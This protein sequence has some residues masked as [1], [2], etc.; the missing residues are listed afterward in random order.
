MKRIKQFVFYGLNDTRNS[1]KDMDD[2]K[3]DLLKKCGPVSH[4]GI[5]GS[6]GVLFC[7]NGSTNDDAISIGT[8]GVY[9]I[10]LT[11][12]GYISNLRFI[13][14]TLIENYPNDVLT[15]Q[16]RLIVDVVY[17]GAEK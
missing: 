4:L 10:D 13:E 3:Y 12:V 16:R 17:E 5:Q 8:T 14:D 6:P 9:E 2:W 15:S 11:G 7:L 1:P